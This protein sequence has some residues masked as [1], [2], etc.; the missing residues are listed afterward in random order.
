LSFCRSI[1]N[2]IIGG[3]CGGIGERF[4]VDPTV[5]RLLVLGTMSASVGIS[6]KTMIPFFL[7]YSVICFL[8]DNAGTRTRV[9][10]RRLTRS[11]HNRRFAGVC[12]GIGEY[13]GTGGFLVRFAVAVVLIVGLVARVFFP[14]VAALFWGYLICLLVMP[15]SM[16]P[17]DVIDI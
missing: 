5:I 2:R 17:A 9:A 4:G 8:S 6:F 15:K 14:I 16:T 7:I 3:V 1:S 12:G 10:Y 11:N 13:F